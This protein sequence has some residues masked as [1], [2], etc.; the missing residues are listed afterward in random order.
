[1]STGEDDRKPGAPSGNSG[2]NE[3]ESDRDTSELY[4][5]MSHALQDRLEHAGKISAEAFDHALRET[6]EWAERMKENYGEDV[7]RVGESIRRDWL[8]AIRYTREQTLK[9]LDLERVQVGVMGFLARLARSA[10]AQLEQFADRVSERLTYKTG[11]IA[12]AGTL[13][14]EKCGQQL[15]LERPKR[16]PPC[17]KCRHTHFSRSF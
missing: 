5:K 14:C 12:G 16:V 1:M 11:E 17:P 13:V 8:D 6:R 15:V 9:N 3:E 7:S 4:E 2:G 10:G